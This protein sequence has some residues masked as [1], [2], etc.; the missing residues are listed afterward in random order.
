MQTGCMAEG[1]E[2]GCRPTDRMQEHRQ[3]AGRYGTEHKM[4]GLDTAR[5][6][7]MDTGIM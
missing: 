7:Y 1:L 2:T 4:Y 3:D 6:D 5:G